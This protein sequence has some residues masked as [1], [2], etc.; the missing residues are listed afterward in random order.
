MDQTALGLLRTRIGDFAAALAAAKRTADAAS[1]PAHALRHAAWLQAAAGD[2]AGALR[3]LDRARGCTDDGGESWFA[4]GMLRVA[5]DDPEGARDAFIA[6]CQVR[7]PAGPVR[8]NQETRLRAW[9]PATNRYAVFTICYDDFQHAFTCFLFPRRISREERQ[10][11]VFCVD[12]GC[13]ELRHGTAAAALLAADQQLNG[14][15][16]WV[17]ANLGHHHW[18]AGRREQADPHYARAKTLFT[19]AGLIPYHFNCG[20]MIWLDRPAS[21]RVLAHGSS[22]DARIGT[23]DWVWH[24]GDAPT[25]RPRC[26]VLVGCDSKFFDLYFPQFLFSLLSAGGDP[27]AI[28]VH[29]HVAGPTPAQLAFLERAAMMFPVSFSTS[30]D[31][32]S[33]RAYYTCLRFMALP[34]VLSRYGCG[35]LV[36]DID[37]AIEPALFAALP[38]IIDADFGFR[39]YSFD[40]KTNR[41]IAGEP[42]S[43]GAHPTYVSATATGARLARFLRDYICTAYDPAALTNWTIDQCA[44]GRGYDLLIRDRTE[45]TVLNFA[46]FARIT[47]LAQESPS[48]A[49]FLREQDVSIADFWDRALPFLAPRSS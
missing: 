13:N 44:I 37:A 41:Q 23:A 40:P 17:H 29:C 26:V 11:Y 27:G 8:A 7:H 30:G 38:T 9:N 22:V 42:W 33:E 6:A 15:S 28:G 25:R 49:A 4:I 20:T 32:P 12:R 1:A 34:E 48:K 35:V 46:F 39:M 16:P 31:G 36:T 19:E 5:D 18:L 43:I 21:L 45:L 14:E 3:T 24:F 47:K 2:L 10:D